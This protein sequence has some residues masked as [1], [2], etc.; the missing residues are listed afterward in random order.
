[1]SNDELLELLTGKNIIDQI[2]DSARI[3][4]PTT[5]KIFNYNMN[6]VDVC[7]AH[8]FEFWGKNKACDNCVSMRTFNENKT[9]V[10]I[11]YNKEKIYMV[12]AVPFEL[13]DRRIVIELLK[14]ITNSLLF[15][16]SGSNDTRQADIHTLIDH[17]NNLALKDA[18]TGIYNRRYINE[19]LP[20]DLI[21]SALNKQNLSVIMTDIDFFKKVND[22]YGH[23]VGD[24][25]LR[26]FAETLSSCI[27][28][29]YD[30][31]A[32]FGGEEFL[33]C[34]PGAKLHK[35]KEIAEAM[36]KAVEEKEIICGEHPLYI[37]ASF[38]VFCVEANQGYG[39]E[40]LLQRVDER[41]YLAKNN[42]RN[43]VES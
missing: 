27:K 31:L 30:W 36:R 35:A 16:S 41:L 22:T 28:R 38:G 42:G 19:K 2:C 25:T 43:R 8:C 3:V 39:M 18:L 11:E 21:N 7:E 20:I 26:S 9:Y 6:G 24:C 14:D 12:T 32:R 23:I 34:L 37:T 4:D 10:K 13:N 29:E 40:E 17:M 33:I 1:M 5:K 15:G